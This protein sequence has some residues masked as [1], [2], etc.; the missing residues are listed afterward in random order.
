M[1]NLKK[2]TTVSIVI[3]WVVFGVSAKMNIN[4]GVNIKEVKNIS[5]FTAENPGVNLIQMAAYTNDDA[6]RTYSLGRRQTG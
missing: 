4:E 3:F 2:I 6:S 1:S 5:Q